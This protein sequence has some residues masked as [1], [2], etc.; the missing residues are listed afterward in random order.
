MKEAVPRLDS[1]EAV[2]VPRVVGGD[3]APPP[4]PSR[5]AAARLV[6][7]PRPA[8]QPTPPEDAV[9]RAAGTRL[10]R[11]SGTPLLPHVR[12]AALADAVHGAGVLRVASLATP[13]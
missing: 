1:S 7:A 2:A 4:D 13:P 10:P 11:P 5:P 3:G 8:T 12:E 9:L 6:D